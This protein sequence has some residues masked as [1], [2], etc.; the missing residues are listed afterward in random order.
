MTKLKIEKN[1][2]KS[3][4][5][6]NEAN[7][8]ILE[9]M[10][11]CNPKDSFLVPKD[12]CNPKSVSSAVSYLRRRYSDFNKTYFTTMKIYNSSNVLTGV[13]VWRDK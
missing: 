11:K 1:I 3:G 8:I 10:L 13:R 4:G 6:V 12:L 9:A 5:K 7:E 2:P